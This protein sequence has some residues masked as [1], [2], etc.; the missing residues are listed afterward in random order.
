MCENWLLNRYLWLC[1]YNCISLNICNYNPKAYINSLVKWIFGLCCLSK[2]K[3]WIKCILSGKLKLFLTVQPTEFCFWFLFLL[4]FSPWIVFVF[5]DWAFCVWLLAVVCIQNIFIEFND[6]SR[7][8]NVGTLN[9]IWK[10][11]PMEWYC[12]VIFFP[13]LKNGL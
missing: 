6:V 3:V 8:D 10:V 4:C 11:K 5:Q 2:R 13:V 7:A 9:I 1:G 12:S